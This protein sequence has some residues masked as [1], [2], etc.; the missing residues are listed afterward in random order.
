M[1]SIYIYMDWFLENKKDQKMPE[2]F[3]LN[4]LI[5]F[6]TYGLLGFSYVK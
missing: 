1:E 5:N 3:L 6:L 4:V 2:K